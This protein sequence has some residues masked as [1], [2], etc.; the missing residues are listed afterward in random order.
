MIKAAL[1][2]AASSGVK[3]HRT[4]RPQLA[5]LS[6]SR[7]TT[8]SVLPNGPEGDTQRSNAKHAQQAGMAGPLAA[9][10]DADHG[11]ESLQQHH[12]PSLAIP[13]EML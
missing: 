1:L 8:C 5:P 4:S 13:L 3:P 10:P 2:A 12:P 7:A 9:V 11:G 6:F